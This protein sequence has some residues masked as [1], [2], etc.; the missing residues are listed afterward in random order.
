MQK[1]VIAIDLGGTKCAGALINSS[2]EILES[3]KYKISSRE[4]DGVA[5]LIND[6]CIQLSEKA[7]DN[8]FK[9]EG[10]GI[11]VPGISY[12]N[13]GCVWAPNI[14]GWV[15]YPLKEFIETNYPHK[16]PVLID[17][18]RAC[19]I[20]GESW[21]GAALG[22]K[23]AIFLAVGTGIGAGIL[24]DGKILRG[25]N[26]IAGA[27]GWMALESEYLEDY[28]KYGCFEYHAS[29]DGLVRITRNWIGKSETTL[30]IKDLKAERIFEAY[31][32]HNPLALRVIDQAIRFWGKALAN[33]IS[34]FNPEIIILGGGVFG[35]GEIFIESIRTEASRWAQPISM[36]KVTIVK[37]SLGNHAQLFGAAKLIFDSYADI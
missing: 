6:M 9:I 36:K 2:G 11:S 8:A 20:L 31:E 7:R 12:Q 32:Q 25:A 23:H 30:N 28:K 13:S 5:Y 4:G 10:I 1:S 19:C 26:D 14:P 15:D 3:K 37:S 22:C 21:L 17:S 24:I 34:L 16:I 35:P 29:G 33:L 27:I 18:D